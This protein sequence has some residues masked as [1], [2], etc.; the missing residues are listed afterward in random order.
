MWIGNL[1]VD[2]SLRFRGWGTHL[3]KALET[4]GTLMRIKI[5]KVLPLHL[6]RGF[7]QLMGYEQYEITAKV[8]VKELRVY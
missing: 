5:V 4:L 8:M 2:S 7:W 3:V 1:M 6:A